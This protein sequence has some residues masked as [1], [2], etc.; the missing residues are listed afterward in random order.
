MYLDSRHR[1]CRILI[2]APANLK[3]R[4]I[5][6]YGDVKMTDVS[7][8]LAKGSENT[9]IPKFDFGT[10]HGPEEVQSAT[11]KELLAEIN[12]ETGKYQSGKPTKTSKSGSIYDIS[13]L[14]T[15]RRFIKEIS[16][17][18]LKSITEKHS[19][20]DIKTIKSLFYYNE[21][22]DSRFLY[23]I[24]PPGNKSQSLVDILNSPPTEDNK[25]FLDTINNITLDI[26]KEINEDDRKGID[27]ICNELKYQT[28]HL[29]STNK[30][31]DE[32][33]F[34]KVNIDE[35]DKTKHAKFFSDETRRF[36]SSIKDIENES[37]II[38]AV[39]TYLRNIKYVHRLHFE[40]TN[41]LSIPNDKYV[42][43]KHIEFY[44]ICKK[45]SERLKKIIVKDTIYISIEDFNWFVREYESEIA[46]L[47]SE[48]TGHKYNKRDLEKDKKRAMLVAYAYLLGLMGATDISEKQ[49]GIVHVVSV[50]C[51]IVHQRKSKLKMGL[52]SKKY[53]L[54]IAAPQ[55]HLDECIHQLENRLPDSPPATLPPSVQHIYTERV[56]WY[57]SAMLQTKNRYDADKEITCAQLELYK[58]IYMT[59]DH[60]QIKENLE[61][62]RLH[63]INAANKFVDIHGIKDGRYEWTKGRR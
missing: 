42:G 27:E 37:R 26:E 45:E 13:S 12:H 44:D 9:Y 48:C 7:K 30:L 50:F 6:N 54:K 52:K 62:Y 3:S 63:M 38:V 57:G 43:N 24:E 40:I 23:F 49:M 31:I 4:N 34:T 35:V 28:S 11:I 32:I 21:S 53:G 19:V 61:Y 15:V 59:L 55:K 46:R 25:K 17:K 29:Q 41:A 18:S 51:S 39:Y 8:K 10:V 58:F 36:H 14:K 47:V 56:K 60:K 16:G 2:V 20:K 1:L 5:E 33:V 22:S